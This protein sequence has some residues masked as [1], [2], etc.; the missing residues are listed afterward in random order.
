[1]PGFWQKEILRDGAVMP[2]NQ[3][4]E[5]DLPTSGLLGSLVLYLRSAAN[6]GALTN[7]RLWR[8]FEYIS[9]IEVIGDGAE[10]IKSFDGPQALAS[11]FY[12]QGVEPL[13]KWGNYNGVTH[14]QVIPINFG[15]FLADELYGLDLSRFSQV[16]LKITNTATS[17]EFS[18]GITLSVIALWAREG[19]GAF[20]GYLREEE[21]KTW[22]P[23]ASSAEYSNLPTRWPIR[24]II[25][26]ARP[27]IGAAS[28]NQNA[29]TIT[30]QM[31]T[32]EFTHKGG[33]VRRFNGSLEV[34]GWM[35]SSEWGREVVTRGEVMRPADGHFD[36]G[37]GYVTS[38]VGAASQVDDPGGVYPGTIIR[39]D[40]QLSSQLVWDVD[41]TSPVEFVARGWGYLHTV[42]LF[43]AT[44][45]N[46]EDLLSVEELKQVAVDITPGSGT[47]TGAGVNAESA[48]VLSRLVG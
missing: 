18:T 16:T 33:Q 43:V 5:L 13:G 12:D 35:A 1:M 22:A 42:P 24:R 30:S 44:N 20:N 45:P 27:A 15:R 8:L 25:L 29:N 6:A 39:A 34:L 48:I 7:V 47:F 17:T 2:F 23:A 14:R 19:A 3:T 41:G 46:L 26:R 40:T 38:I 37:I 32:I 28:V 4:Y 11:A 10:V 21:W 31:A 9:K 36:C